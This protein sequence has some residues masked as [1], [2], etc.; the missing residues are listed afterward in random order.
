[1]LPRS[2]ACRNIV[3]SHVPY[4]HIAI[5]GFLTE[6]VAR[7]LL[8]S[9]PTFAERYRR[10]R[11]GE[12]DDFQ[13]TPL[14]EL[15]GSREFLQWLAAITG[16]DDLL[17][18]NDPH[19]TRFQEAFNGQ[20]L[21][22]Y[23]GFNF[24]PKTHELRRLH[25]T[26]FMNETWDSAWGGALSLRSDRDSAQG[27]TATSYVPLFNRCVIVE[28]GPANFMGFDKISFPSE[29]TTQSRRTIEI[30][31][32]T[33]NV[34]AA[35]PY[36]YEERALPK[37]IETGRVLTAQD[38]DGLRDLVAERNELIEL[39]EELLTRHTAAFLNRSE[40][41]SPEFAAELAPAI[42]VLGYA[43]PVEVLGGIYPDGAVTR[44]LRF[45]VKTLRTA[46]GFTFAA[47]VPRY[48]P[49]DTTLEIYADSQQIYRGAVQP[50]SELRAWCEFHMNAGEVYVFTV[51]FSNVFVP[52]QLKINSDD[53]RLTVMKP[54][55]IFEHA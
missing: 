53:R 49:A 17:F 34:P 52:R 54:R 45:S 15:F 4:R 37:E 25:M 39:R 14:E 50:H 38:V 9:F 3:R 44:E 5:D 19:A 20:S 47:Y 7:N 22:P 36:F 18:R 1:M 13:P 32:Y 51:R 41:L 31:F 23:A 29:K 33:R 30:A 10:A 46:R 21:A 8:E 27:K 42:P 16:I 6:A 12:G 11:S 35:N 28:T 26:I 48:L 55:V 43:E 24:H 40:D 2:L